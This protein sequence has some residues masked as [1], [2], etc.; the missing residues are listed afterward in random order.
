MRGQG[1]LCMP[2]IW[3]L[4]SCKQAGLVQKWELFLP[5]ST[6][7]S[8]WLLVG[9]IF[10]CAKLSIKKEL[11]GQIFICFLLTNSLPQN[12]KWVVYNSP[13]S[14]R[15]KLSVSKMVWWCWQR[16]MAWLRAAACSIPPGTIQVWCCIVSLPSCNTQLCSSCFCV[17]RCCLILF[18]FGLV[19]QQ[20]KLCNFI[21]CLGAWLGCGLCAR[22]GAVLSLV[23]E[24]PV[25]EPASLGMGLRKHVH[26]HSSL[27][28]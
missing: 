1:V 4:L 5:N 24:T 15:L 25:S 10:L 22:M 12:W 23:Q 16:T 2:H 3:R 20:Q 17:S 14:L 27:H 6:T 9:G 28:C 11:L 8:A 7:A 21:S 13:A 18:D 26:I 19:Q